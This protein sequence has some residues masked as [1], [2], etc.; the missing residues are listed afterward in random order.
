MAQYN[1]L[2]VT[3]TERTLSYLGAV[4][5]GSPVDLELGDLKV[6]IITTEDSLNIDPSRVYTA[7]SINVNVFYDTYL[8]RSNLMCTLLSPEL[9]ERAMEL[10]AEGVVRS[11]Y[12]WYIP[13]MTVKR[14]M[15]PLSRHVQHWRVSLANALCQNERPLTFS[16]E[17]VVV[18][19]ILAY[20]DYDYIMAMA[21]ELQLR[22]G[23]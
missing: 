2:Y 3:P 9:Q 23:A 1:R 19:E 12:D 8:Q 13:Y 15:P 4:M 18:E 14:G 21:A 17:H 16:D 6:E 7:Q 10:N 5:S 22:H 11:F 20:P